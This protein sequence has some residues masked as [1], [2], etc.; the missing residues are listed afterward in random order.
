MIAE[1]DESPRAEAIRWHVRIAD[2]SAEDW[3]AFV[4]WLGADA[5]HAEA[6]EAIEAADAEVGRALLE[7]LPAQRHAANDDVP[8]AL[9]RWWWGG[10][11]DRYQDFGSWRPRRCGWR[12]RPDCRRGQFR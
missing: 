3:E 2:G 7:V 9:R 6:Y 1:T 4:V 10:V 5:A 8:S 11:V 12:K